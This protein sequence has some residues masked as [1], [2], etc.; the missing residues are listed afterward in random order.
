[1]NRIVIILS[2]KGAEAPASSIDA[3]TGA[4]EQIGT[5]DVLDLP[6]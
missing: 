4:P 2:G 1:M 5:D 6:F 3:R